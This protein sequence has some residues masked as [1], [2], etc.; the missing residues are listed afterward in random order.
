MYRQEMIEAKTKAELEGKIA[1]LRQHMP[2]VKVI[3]K[4]SLCY[5]HIGKLVW[6]ATMRYECKKPDC[7]K[8]KTLRFYAE[9]QL[10]SFINEQDIEN[11]WLS[12]YNKHCGESHVWE[13]TYEPKSPITEL[14]V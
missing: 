5:N 10:N 3:E 6:K 8:L 14:T 11:F 4:A 7:P 1:E 2:S 13:L 9:A 12:D